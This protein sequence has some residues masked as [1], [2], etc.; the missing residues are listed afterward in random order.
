[1]YANNG[2]NRLST[3]YANTAGCRTTSSPNALSVTPTPIKYSTTARISFAPNSSVP[4]SNPRRTASRSKL[5]EA[6]DI[7]WSACARGTPMDSRY[8]YSPMSA[9][10]LASR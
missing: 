6:C 3:S 7:T 10:S 5:A 2:S 9:F 4:G 8:S 1:M